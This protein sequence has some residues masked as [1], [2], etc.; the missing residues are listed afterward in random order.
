MIFVG[1]IDMSYPQ[2]VYRFMRGL[3]CVVCLIAD[4]PLCAGGFWAC[5]F[6]PVHRRRFVPNR[7]VQENGRGDAFLIF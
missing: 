4:L 5:G 7:T 3:V 1:I 6:G 2:V